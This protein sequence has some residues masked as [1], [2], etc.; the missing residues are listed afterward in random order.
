MLDRPNMELPV[1]HIGL[2][3]DLRDDYEDRGYS[4]ESLS[5]FDS[6]ETIEAIERSLWCHGYTTERIGNVRSLAKKLVEGQRWSMVFN[7]A[8]GLSGR[9]RE[10]QV[11]CLLEAYDIPYVFSDPLTQAVT[12]DK[13][14]AKRLVRDSGIPTPRFK[15]IENIKDILSCDLSYP[16]FVK[17]IGEGTGKGC[18]NASRI[19]DQDQ[20]IHVATSLIFRFNQPVLA[21]EYL[22]G[23]E[24]TVGILGN[25][26]DARVLGVMEILLGE[27][28]EE[29]AYSYE[30]KANYLDRV[31][32][33]LADDE[34]AT[35]A[36]S[37]ALA[38]YH[39]LGCLD[40]SRLD[41]RSDALGVPNFIEANTLAGLNPIHS[42]LPILAAKTGMPYE[43]LILEITKAAHARH[44]ITGHVHS[45][46]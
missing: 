12:L 39:A 30:N 1:Q 33:K 24:F 2:T 43:T 29:N 10:A 42:D 6:I 36:A 8:E 37:N 18:S 3:Y 44:G 19:M 15:V 9:S 11:P 27:N 13:S 7:L 21:E 20:F 35:Q 5:E 17:P 28:A 46:F 4:E 14:I 22:P 16:V 23:R 25:G 40:A 32:Y 34:E 45:M 26:S 38:A 31:T 41:F